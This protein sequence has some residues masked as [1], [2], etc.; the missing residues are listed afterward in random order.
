[1]TQEEIINY[2]RNCVEFLGYTTPHPNFPTATYWYKEG[3]PPLALLSFHRYWNWIME[4]VEAIEKTYSNFHGY[5]GVFIN[6]NG[7]TIQGT[8]LRT[9]PENPHYA[10]YNEVILT[11]KKESV[12]EAINQFLTWY[13]NNK[14]N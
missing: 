2:N 5:F 14:I 9:N 8:K 12:V 6:P 7:C 1:M 10:Y 13:K 3:K 4:V 11:D